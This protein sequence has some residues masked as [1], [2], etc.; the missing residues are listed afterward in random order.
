MLEPLRRKRFRRMVTAQF[1]AETGDGI[2]LVALPLYVWARTESEVWT[3]LTFGIELALGVVLAIM[4]GL[5]ADIFNRQRVL[6]VSYVIRSVL[7][8]AAF[9]IDPLLFAVGAGVLARALGNADNPSFDALIPDQAEG[10]LQQVVAIRRLVQAA[11]I[12]I[13]PAVGALIVAVVGPRPA[14]LLN[15][16]LFGLAF[17]VLAGISGLDHKAPERL[18]GF[19]GVPLSKAAKDLAAGM[20]TVLRTPGVRRLLLHTTFALAAVGLVIASALVFYERDLG[21]DSYWFGL[22]IG[23][24]GIGSAC[25]LALSGSHSFS[26]PL[27]RIILLATPMYAIACAAGAAV[28]WPALMPIS[29]FVWGLAFGPEM[30]VSEIFLVGQIPEDQ[31]GRAF[32]GMGVATALG[33]AAGSFLAAPLLHMFSARQ[34]IAG[35]GAAI[36]IGSLLWVRPAIQGDG[37]P[38]QRVL[39][40]GA[41]PNTR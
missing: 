31:R 7:L 6:L 27:P 10:D 25:G 15:A 39:G 9:V 35:T 4:G 17:V 41:S 22:A 5:L 23:G 1:V 8:V 32:A 18:R 24:Y 14:L 11:S 28:E 38:G 2:S 29:W 40:D 3:S 26:L 20:R 12:T 13:G 34:V 30:V 33:M 21:V 37:W 19:E 16:V 36:L